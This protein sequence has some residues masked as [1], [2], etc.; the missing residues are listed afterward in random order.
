MIKYIQHKGYE[1][2]YRDK[3]VVTHLAGFGGGVGIAGSGE[4]SGFQGTTSGYTS[5]GSTPTHVDNIDKYAYASDANATDVGDLTVG[6]YGASGLSSINYGFTQGGNSRTS[7]VDKY[8]FA[9]D[10]NATDVCDLTTARTEMGGSSGVTHGYSQGGA[11]GSTVIEKFS[12]STELNTT[13]VGDLTV[14]RYGVA[15]QQ[16]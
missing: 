2:L 16:A 12:Y 7:V 14:G 10:A 8:T 11:G 3:L 15:G 5:G 9:S 4:T 13:D 6:G 1:R